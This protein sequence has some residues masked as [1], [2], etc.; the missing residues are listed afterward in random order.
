LAVVLV[1]RA[2]EV[3]NEEPKV[4]KEIEMLALSTGAIVALAIAIVVLVV[5][6]IAVL[7]RARRS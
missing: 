1:S 2:D 5:V 3:D 6:F 4:G 7:Q